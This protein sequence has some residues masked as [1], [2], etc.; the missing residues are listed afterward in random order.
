MNEDICRRHFL[1]NMYSLGY[2]RFGRAA[3]A[4]GRIAVDYRRT[5]YSTA[6]ED[7]TIYEAAKKENAASVHSMRF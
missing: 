7:P 1:C 5:L 4:V 3:L 2:V 6:Y